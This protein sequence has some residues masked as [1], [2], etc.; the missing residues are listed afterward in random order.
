MG[1]GDKRWSV[2]VESTVSCSKADSDS[3]PLGWGLR[4]CISDKLPEDAD[5]MIPRPHLSGKAQEF[6]IS[7]RKDPISVAFNPRG[8]KTSSM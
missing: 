1:F 2:L 4:A 6:S 5:S 3:V 8:M 7:L